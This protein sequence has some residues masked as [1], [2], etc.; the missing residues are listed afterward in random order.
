MIVGTAGHVDHGKTALVKA[1]TGIDTDRLPEE[2]RRGITLELGFAHLDLFG[3]R[4]VGVIDVPGH[5]RFVRAM[6]AGAG[7]VDVAMVVVAVDEG[8]MPQTREHVDICRLLGVRRGVLVVTKCDLLPSLGEGWLELLRPELEALGAGT[9]LE[10]AKVLQVSARTGEGVDALKAELL[11]LVTELDGAPRS[12]DGP[13]FMPVDR[14]FTTKG[15]GL[16]VTGSLLSGRVKPGDEVDLLPGLAGP[17]RVRGVQTHGVGVEEAVA[18]A[19]VAVNLPDLDTLRVHRGMALVR[20]GELRETRSLDV[21]LTLLPAVEAPLPRRS[22]QLVSIGTSLVEGVVRLL[23]VDALRPGESC[24]GQ[25]RFAAPVAAMVGQRFLVRGTRPLSGRG[26]TVGGGRVLSLAWRRRRRGGAERLKALAEAPLDERL[27]WFLTEAGYGGLTQAELFVSASAPMKELQR[28]LDVLASKG[29]IVLADKE[30][31]RYLDRQVLDALVARAVAHLDAFHRDAPERDGVSR[32]ELRQRL[33]VPHEKTFHRVLSGLLE[34]G[35]I[36]GL[37]ELVRLK[38]R[39]RRFDE[40]A[41]RLRRA[42]AEALAKGA[43]APPSVSE[44]AT[45]LVAPEARLVELLNALVAERVVVRAGALFFDAGV[46]EALSRR[47]VEHLT[48]HRSITTQGFKEMVGQ[49]RK[50]TIPLAEYFDREKVTLRVGEE[51]VLR[52]KE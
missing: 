20:H 37:S 30:Q 23:D 36:E 1:L 13:L 49:S 2:K 46:V 24:F 4:R 51:R 5:E 22:R 18:G 7:G 41:R 19:R 10:G 27:R 28:A 9:F 38:G 16:V 52:K 26:S 3:G 44:L 12:P 29:A 8:V 15:F 50:F 48:S 14:A 11:R 32:E 33:A 47:L 25:V 39:G 43:L 45:R 6:A 17:W 34:G 31:R 35:R 42:A 21:E 40:E